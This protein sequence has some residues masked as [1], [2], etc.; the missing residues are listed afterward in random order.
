MRPCGGSVSSGAFGP[1]PCDPRSSSGAFGPHTYAAK[2]VGFVRVLLV[3]SREPK[4][5][6]GSF[7]CLRF[8]P[9]RHGGR[10]VR[11]CAFGPFPFAL[12]FVR[13]RSVQFHASCVIVGC[14]RSIPVRSG[15]DR[16]RSGAFGPFPYALWVIECVRSN[17]VFPW[18]RWLCS[19][20]FGPFTLGVVG[21]VHSRAGRFVR[22]C[23]I[24]PFPCALGV[25]GFVCVRSVHSRA[26]WGSSCTFECGRSIPVRPAGRRVR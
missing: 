24:G 8:I 25:V 10:R 4:W 13:V 19:F 21:S 17:N 16:N 15:G 18:G 3:N 2:G 22:I 5:L 1:F 12:V 23:A 14:V 20:A 7:R 11:S 26:P 6:S 9:V